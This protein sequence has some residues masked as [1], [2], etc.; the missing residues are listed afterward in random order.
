MSRSLLNDTTRMGDVNPVAGAIYSADGYMDTTS[1]QVGGAG[2][3]VDTLLIVA[4]ADG[5]TITVNIGEDAG[6]LTSCTTTLDATTGA[7]TTAAAAAVV[8]TINATIGISNLVF[9]S[10]TAGLILITGKQKGAFATFVTTA[11][12]VGATLTGPTSPATSPADATALQFGLMC[13][14]T[15]GTRVQGTAQIGSAVGTGTYVAQVAVTPDITTLVTLGAGDVLSFTVNGDFDG[16]GA[17]DYTVQVNGTG[18][19]ATDIDNAVAALNLAL[20]ANS[21]AVTEAGNAVTFTA[22]VAGVG[23]TVSG[24]GTA[25]GVP[26]LITFAESGTKANAIP[27]GGGVVLKSHSIEQD[28]NGVAQYTSGQ[29]FSGLTT[30]KVIVRL[31]DGIT[32]AVGDPCFVRTGIVTTTT[33]VKGAFSNVSDSGD[34]VPISAFGFKATWL[35]AS[36]TDMDGNNTAPLYLQRA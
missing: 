15:T 36:S 30:G 19:P 12:T 27:D 22:E 33:G 32:V 21:V 18:T 8:D 10:S 20:P 35:A 9:A 11:S 16:L 17:R 29:A 26:A 23:F 4:A 31:D 24:Y 6:S 13:E 25:S 28:A 1:L 7:S 2:A 14:K 3:Q 5:N 34:N